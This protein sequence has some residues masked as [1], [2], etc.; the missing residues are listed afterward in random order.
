MYK[1][2]S[3]YVCFVF[4]ESQHQHCLQKHV[5]Q[6]TTPLVVMHLPLQEMLVQE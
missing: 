6:Q 3:P 5:Y 1:H 2:G 4:K